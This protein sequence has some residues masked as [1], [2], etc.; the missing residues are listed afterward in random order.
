MQ[1][2]PRKI[3]SVLNKDDYKY[4]VSVGILTA[5]LVILSATNTTSAFTSI[6]LIQHF[7]LIDTWLSHKPL[8]KNITLLGNP[9]FLAAFLIPIVIHPLLLFNPFLNRTFGTNPLNLF[10]IVYSIGVSLTILIIIEVNKILKTAE[11]I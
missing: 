6:I 2:R 1:Q 3:E 9:I 5:L 4:V 11:G 7:I 8:I 10:Q